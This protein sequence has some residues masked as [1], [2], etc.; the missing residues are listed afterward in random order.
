MPKKQNTKVHVN[1]FV[2]SDLWEEIC[3]KFPDHS[4][5]NVIIDGL[6]LLAATKRRRSS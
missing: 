6:V 1:A 2:P 3:D 4:I 5:T